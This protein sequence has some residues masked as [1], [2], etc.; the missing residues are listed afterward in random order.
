MDLAAGKA[1]EETA[2]GTAAAGGIGIHPLDP[3]L[4]KFC[5][6]EG[7]QLL[8]DALCPGP[9]FL[10]V[11]ETTLRTLLRDRGCI[12]AVVAAEEPGELVVGQGNTAVGTHGNIATIRTLEPA[13]KAAPV[14]EEDNPVVLLDMLSDSVQ[15]LFAEGA[16]HPARAPLM[17]KI[18]DAN[19]GKLC[20]V[21]AVFEFEQVV[22]PYLGVVEALKRW[23]C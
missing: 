20:L 7:G 11:R 2:V 17:P 1:L 19:G 9:D 21:G 14:V 12:A 22:L 16:V 13:G 3:E 23:G 18:E 10:K 6:Q 5:P 15:E 8:L 4:G